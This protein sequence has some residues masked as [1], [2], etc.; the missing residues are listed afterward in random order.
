[1]QKIKYFVDNSEKGLFCTK[2]TDS[3]LLKRR[4]TFVKEK[5]P[6]FLK[7]SGSQGPRIPKA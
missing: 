6:S 7:V 5:R 1:M 2:Y 3:V 4:S